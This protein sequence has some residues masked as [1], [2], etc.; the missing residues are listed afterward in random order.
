MVRNDWRMKWS[1]EQT[2]RCRLELFVFLVAHEAMHATSGHP[3]KWSRRVRDKHGL[4]HTRC[5][6]QSMENHCNT[7]G[8]E[9]MTEWREEW[10]RKLRAQ[11]RRAVARRRATLVK[12][13]APKPK[14]TSDEKI[15]HTLKLI[16]QW[17]TKQKR[18]ATYIKKYRRRLRALERHAA[19]RSVERQG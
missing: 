17:E 12:A 18:A 11:Y 6:T 8:H 16:G 1:R 19:K 13:K 4:M 2:F 10:R 3:S 14:P 9:I 15:E 7:R 5:N